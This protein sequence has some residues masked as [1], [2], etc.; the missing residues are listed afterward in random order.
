[1]ALAIAGAG[2]QLVRV[3][4]M[5]SWAFLSRWWP[6]VAAGVALVTAGVLWSLGR[7]LPSAARTPGSSGESRWS[8]IGAMVTTITAGGALVFTALSLEATRDQIDVARQGQI[9]DR[10]TRAV[11]QLGSEGPENTHR[12]LGGI[13]ALERVA[14][15]SSRDQATMVEVLSAFLRSTSRRTKG[16]VC[17]QSPADVAA[18]FTVLARRDVS[19]DPE[20]MVID[21]REVCLRDVRAVDGNLTGMSL[22]GSDLTGANLSGAHF[23]L[24]ALSNAT[25]VDASL[26]RAHLDSGFVIAKNADLTRA[27]LDSAK[28]SGADFSGSTFVGAD[29]DYADLGSADFSG[30][31]LTGA[32]HNH[33][34]KAD[35]AVKDSATV[36]AWW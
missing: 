22:L 5:P 7:Q 1:M 16:E 13:Y 24:T 11:D 9:N 2:W 25:L 19:L 31:N 26:Y 8:R 35:R 28:L 10:Y 27:R 12:R 36:G 20:P 18:A 23:A 32:T 3:G 33:D 17:P 15:D 29:F 30:A 6:A 21:L 4:A 34:T 14:V